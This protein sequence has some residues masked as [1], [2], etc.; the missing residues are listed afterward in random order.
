MAEVQVRVNGRSYAVG[1]EDGQEEHVQ[2]LAA[3]FDK[4]VAEVAREVGHLGDTRLFLLGAL[5]LADELAETRGALTSASADLAQTT[6]DHDRGET[7]AIAALEAAAR[8]VEELAK[9][10]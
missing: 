1:C 9:T 4:H 7:R 8:R 10:A 2:T 6:A 5:L 3:V